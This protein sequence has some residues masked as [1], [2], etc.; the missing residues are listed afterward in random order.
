MIWLYLVVLLFSVVGLTVVTLEWRRGVRRGLLGPLSTFL[1]TFAAAG[2]ALFWLYTLDGV[3]G[4]EVGPASGATVAKPATSPPESRKHPPGEE[5]PTRQV[6][7]SGEPDAGPP[8]TRVG[9]G[10][11]LTPNFLAGALTTALFT[12]LAQIHSTV[13]M[14][15]LHRSIEELRRRLR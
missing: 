13:T 8:A 3:Y 6:K 10:Q 9:W 4:P 1:L 7:A 11:I 5:A 15:R 2:L 12:I 14:S